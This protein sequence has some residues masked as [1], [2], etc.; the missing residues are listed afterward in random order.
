MIGAKRIVAL[1]EY[2]SRLGRDLQ[3]EQESAS[4]EERVRRSKKIK[5]K[6]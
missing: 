6:P 4:R 2:L 3:T 5:K 1:R